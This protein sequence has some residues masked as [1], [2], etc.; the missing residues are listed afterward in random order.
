M[1]TGGV[2]S[3]VH[4]RRHHNYY[5]GCDGYPRGLGIDTF[6][7]IPRDTKKFKA[8]LT[9]KRK[10]LDKEYNEAEE[11]ERF[12]EYPD[13]WEHLYEVDLDK[14]SFNYM[15]APLY[16]LDHMPPCDI[17]LRGIGV[18]DHYGVY[19]FTHDTPEEYRWPLPAPTPAIS[20]DLQK[21]YST[22]DEAQK[23][24]GKVSE[25][26]VDQLLGCSTQ[27]S[28]REQVRVR[29]LELTVGTILTQP[30]NGNLIARNIIGLADRLKSMRLQM[31]I[32]T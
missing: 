2:V 25:V 3:Y 17:F 22:N 32:S 21:I 23:K 7:E 10:A 6:E 18:Y 5:Y 8:W 27:L 9:K 29:L 11:K 31:T 20:E 4:R 12:N 19:S 26:A 30:R 16:R 28:I 14:L 15:F 24:S 13:P 1:G